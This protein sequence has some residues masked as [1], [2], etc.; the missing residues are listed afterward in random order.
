M[1][2]STSRRPRPGAHK[3]Q[4]D[5]REDRR[6]VT[7]TAS[8]CIDG[9]K[10]ALPCTVRDFHSQGARLSISNVAAVPEMF[11]L[12]IRSD[13]FLARASVAW[14]KSSEIG[15][16]LIRTGKMFEEDRFRREQAATYL[17]V[18]DNLRRENAR[19]EQEINDQKAAA[20]MHAQQ[21]AHE[22]NR[23]MQIMGIDPRHPIS[24]ERIKQ[25]YRQQAMVRHPDQGGSME[26]FHE[27]NNV[28]RALMSS[29]GSMEENEANPA[30]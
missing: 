30:L 10:M 29:I 28:Y 15:V 1:F 8:I 26:E 21:A 23:L 24:E 22:Q 13:D 2:S 18:Q 19:K 20:E 4:I 5:R 12:I 11:L 16:R 17:Q 9:D 27:L 14:R 6:V 25:A 7:K 3:K